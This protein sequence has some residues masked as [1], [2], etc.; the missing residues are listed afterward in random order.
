[1]LHPQI[2]FAAEVLLAICILSAILVA[3]IAAAGF[4]SG[5]SI[6]QISLGVGSVIR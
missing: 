3:A 2:L 5:V 1:V 6:R 4:A